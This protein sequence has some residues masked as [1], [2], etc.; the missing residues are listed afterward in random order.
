MSMNIS[1]AELKALVTT[2]DSQG[3]NNNK[4]DGDEVSV[5]E[6]QLKTLGYDDTQINGIYSQLGIEI[7]SQKNKTQE[8][9]GDKKSK[10]TDVINLLITIINDGG[11]I[12]A[13]LRNALEKYADDPEYLEI[14]AQ[15]K[16]ILDEINSIGYNSRKDVEA[17]RGKVKKSLGIGRRD[18]FQRKILNLLVEHARKTQVA[19]EYK[20]FQDKFEE[21]YN[22]GAMTLEEA[23]NQAKEALKVSRE[24]IK[25]QDKDFDVDSYFKYY[26]YKLG[27]RYFLDVPQ[28][29]RGVLY[30]FENT[31]IKDRVQVIR[32]RAI[33]KAEGEG[34]GDVRERA[35]EIM[36]EAGQLDKYT[37]IGPL[38]FK[39]WVTENK[40]NAQIMVENRVRE[41]NVEA[42]KHRTKEEIMDALGKNTELFTALTRTNLI[43]ENKDGTYDLTTLSRTIIEEIGSDYYLDKMSD[44]SRKPISEM[45]GVTTQLQDELK[46]S[47]LSEKQAKKLVELCGCEVQGKNWFNLLKKSTLGVFFGAVTSGGAEANRAPENIKGKNEITVSS[48]TGTG[49]T[50][51]MQNGELI[52][53]NKVQVDLQTKNESNDLYNVTSNIY[54]YVNMITDLCAKG[55]KFVLSNA[56]RG[57][58]IGGILGAIDGLLT[59]DRN[60]VPAAEINFSETSFEEYVK[61]TKSRNSK[62]A[63]LL[64]LLAATYCDEKG[65][66]DYEGYKKLLERVAGNDVLNKK[67]L[68]G[69]LQ[70]MLGEEEPDPVD[71]KLPKIDFEVPDLEIPTID[72]LVPPEECSAIVSRKTIETSLEYTVEYGDT[73]GAIVNAF[74][75]EL[76]ASCKGRLYGKNG[77]VNYLK[78]A[79]STN[80]DGSF[81]GD[82]YRKL[83]EG[84][85][86]PKTLILPG[87]INGHFRVDVDTVVKAE[88]LTPYKRGALVSSAGNA[89]YD[90]K[91]NAVDGCDQN[92]S[93]D[94]ASLEDSV[95]NLRKE[96]PHKR[97]R[98]VI[99]NTQN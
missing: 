98:H 48:D 47:T 55:S 6:K 40:S 24:A 84:G 82:T 60:E 49:L 65:N 51:V 78:K 33:Q 36:E 7:S 77:A 10:E 58:I 43:V 74:Y 44:K 46:W 18:K 59:D 85:N 56:L 19:K 2:V 91:F 37:H 29:N 3:N 8:C 66:W 5:F 67:E 21:I 31:Y 57:A 63:D 42:A 90:T 45:L 89:T 41:I 22:N 64:I 20:E 94:G 13:E 26:E 87:E 17:L 32:A 28:E 75:P 62:Y 71:P 61:N 88:D 97:Y 50:Y 30:E 12:V 93:A 15:V 83:L 16:E 68:I 92:I 1:E 70:R 34:K 72:G 39:E 11:D 73:W 9:P 69:E 79:L 96:N 95:N 81:N 80:P 4:I 14:Q 54:I 52:D 38:S 27:D 86:L 35:N 99:D 76:V 25:K 53:P 23:M